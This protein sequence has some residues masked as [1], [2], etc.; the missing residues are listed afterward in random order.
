MP[1]GHVA[2][3]VSKDGTQSVS[4]E[5]VDQL[6]ADPVFA[7]LQTRLLACAATDSVAVL[8]LLLSHA[9]PAGL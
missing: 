6:V 9:H 8:N 4:N 1:G 7:D 5:K 2:R 3:T